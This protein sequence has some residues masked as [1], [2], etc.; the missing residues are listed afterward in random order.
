[1]TPEDPWYTAYRKS[2]KYI[3][4]LENALE[5][6]RAKCVMLIEKL[7]NV[8]NDTNWKKNGLSKSLDDYMTQAKNEIEEQIREAGV[9]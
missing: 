9:R 1:M 5:E 2:Q 7:Q 4:Y 3:T 6:E 8:A